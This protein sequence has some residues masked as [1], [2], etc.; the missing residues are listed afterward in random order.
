MKQMSAESVDHR[1]CSAIKLLLMPL[2]AFATA[3]NSEEERYCNSDGNVSSLSRTWMPALNKAHTSNTEIPPK[4]PKSS[5]VSQVSY[6][7]GCL[8]TVIFTSSTPTS[9]PSPCDTT[10]ARG[11][12]Y[13]NCLHRKLGYH[14]EKSIHGLVEERSGW[15]MNLYKFPFPGDLF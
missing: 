15:Q 5:V 7:Q 13:R 1:A 14:P 8:L 4:I 9:E 2:R 3:C 12:L 10:P 6:K 11:I